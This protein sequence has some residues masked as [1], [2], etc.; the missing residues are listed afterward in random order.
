M[1]SHER[2][3]IMNTIL[4]VIAGLVGAFIVVTVFLIFMFPKVLRAIEEHRQD[5]YKQMLN[6][7]RPDP[8]A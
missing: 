8:K 7:C 1:R 2:G 6:R 3:I 5:E 4:I